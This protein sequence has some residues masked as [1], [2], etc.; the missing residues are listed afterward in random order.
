MGFCSIC[1]NT[2][3]IK[4]G[5]MSYMCSTFD[6][7]PLTGEQ[8]QDDQYLAVFTRGCFHRINSVQVED[9]KILLIPNKRARKNLKIP[10]N[11]LPVYFKLGKDLIPMAFVNYV[12]KDDREY[13]ML[14][15]GA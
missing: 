6:P 7:T 4:D 15:R 14:T 1:K 12:T 13:S 5:V 9:G 10:R 11:E 2:C 3:K 8:L